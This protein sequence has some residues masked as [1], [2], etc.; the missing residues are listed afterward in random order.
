[1]RAIQN[2]KSLG[3]T[4]IIVTHKPNILAAVDNIAVMQEGQ[5]ALCGGRDAVLRKM[6]EMRREQAA[7]QAKLRQEELERQAQQQ[8]TGE[9]D[10]PVIV[11]EAGHA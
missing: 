2:L 10:A 6:E 1:M 5:I 9:D 4:V 7:R 8:A 3:S 11:T